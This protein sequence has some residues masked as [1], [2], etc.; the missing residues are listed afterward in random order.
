MK[1]SIVTLIGLRDGEAV[2]SNIEH[3]KGLRMFGVVQLIYKK[4]VFVSESN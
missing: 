4:I 1:G 3:P 2:L